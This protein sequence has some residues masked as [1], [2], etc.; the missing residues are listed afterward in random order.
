MGAMANHTAWGAL[1]DLVIDLPPGTGEVPLTLATAFPLDCAV[2]VSTP[3]RL[4]IVR[5]AGRARWAG[6]G[7]ARGRGRLRGI[8]F[9]CGRWVSAR[10]AG[11]EDGGE[12]VGV[13][14]ALALACW[15]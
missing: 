6:A 11:R 13:L 9:S 1:D 5:A 12:S 3:H 2:V 8:A 7:R 4:A 14:A 15:P 10:R